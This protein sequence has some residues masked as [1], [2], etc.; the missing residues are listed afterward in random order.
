MS[1]DKKAFE[2]QVGVYSEFIRHFDAEVCGRR[3]SAPR[4][5]D[6]L[7]RVESELGA[8]MPFLRRLDLAAV[9][10]SELAVAYEAVLRDQPGAPRLSELDDWL[11]ERG[12]VDHKGL[13]VFLAGHL[14]ADRQLPRLAEELA[15]AGG[16]V[17]AALAALV[18]SEPPQSA[19]RTR[20]GS[21]HEV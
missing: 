18:R 5:L 21:S 16:K 20:E 15:F 8:L 10:T 14:A 4:S 17:S 11:D 19:I 9:V 7:K 6:V 1:I 3:V 2:I 13:A 12:L